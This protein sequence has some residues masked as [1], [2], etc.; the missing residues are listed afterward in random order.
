MEKQQGRRGKRRQHL[1]SAAETLGW[2]TALL[3]SDF[4][5]RT[6][7]GASIRSSSHSL[8]FYSW[9]PSTAPSQYSGGFRSDIR[10]A[11]PAVSLPSCLP[12]SCVQSSPPTELFNW[13]ERRS[14]L[15]NPKTPTK[16]TFIQP[17]LSAEMKSSSF[18]EAFFFFA[19]KPF[20]RVETKG[21]APSQT[22][23][24]AF[25]LVLRAWLS[26]KESNI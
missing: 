12:N 15:Y 2:N 3:L 24:P 16:K 18:E 14:P 10:Y 5:T 9:R 4:P 22:T 23:L 7:A 25:S 11:A 1:T 13:Q 21:P 17:P 26:R 6:K 20:S 19:G 8:L